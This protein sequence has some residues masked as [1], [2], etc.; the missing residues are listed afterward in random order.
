MRTVIS[1][2]E[3]FIQDFG[4]AY[5][6]FGLPK[7]MG[8]VVGLLLSTDEPMSLDEITGELGVSKGPV[9]QVMSRLRDNRLVHRMNVPGNR[10]D[11]YVAHDDIFGKAFNNHAG[12]LHQNQL[13]A[14]KYHHLIHE[15]GELSEENKVFHRRVKEMEAFYGLMM[16]HLKNFM[17]EWQETKKK[18]DFS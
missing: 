2:K 16:K 11:F 9:S 1:L 14:E 18:T 7:L 15:E 4:E 5:Q 13:I 8:Y 3:E 10:K 12:L 17:N 6:T